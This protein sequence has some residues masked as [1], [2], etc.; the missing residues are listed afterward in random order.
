MNK[1]VI[2][3]IALFMAM[4]IG[5]EC[6]PVEALAVENQVNASTYTPTLDINEEETPIEVVGELEDQRS[7]YTKSFRLSDGTVSTVEYESDVHYKDENGEWQPIDNSL[8]FE[9]AQGNTGAEAE[10]ASLAAETAENTEDTVDTQVQSSEQEVTDSSANAENVEE[11]GDQSA[12]E[13]SKDNQNG[14][15]AAVQSQVE[16]LTEVIQEQGEVTAN[17][18]EDSIAVQSQSSDDV[19]ETDG[20]K[21][22][23]GKV[24]FKFAK[25]ANQKNLVR[26]NQGKYKLSI[27]LQKKNKNKAVEIE[28]MESVASEDNNTGDLAS[29]MVAEN[30]SS[31][32]IYKNIQDGIDLQYVTSGSNLKENIIVNQTKENYQFSFEI[33]AQNLAIKQE[34][35]TIVLYDS[36]TNQQV[37]EM[38]AMYME[39]SNGEQSDG[40]TYSLTQKNKKKYTLT[41]TADAAWINATERELPIIIDPS[42][43]TSNTG[44]GMEK[45]E[46]F[47]YYAAEGGSVYHNGYGFLGY[48]S[49]GD[50]L[51]RH[52]IQFK[53]LPS[54]PRGSVVAEAK[55]YYAQLGYSTTDKPWKKTQTWSNL[56]AISNTVS[57]YQYLSK[58][59]TGK[60][61]GW[62]ITELVKKRYKANDSNYSSLAL[63]NYDESTLNNKKCAKATIN[64][65]NTNG[66][67]KDGHPILQ[68]TYRDTRGIEDYYTNTS[69]SVGQAGTAYV[70]NYNN[71]LTLIKND[72]SNNG[73]VMDFVLS[74]VYNSTVSYANFTT[75]ANYDW[76]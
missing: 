70:G 22:E 23:A 33:K 46:I 64:Q 74:H 40:I 71:Q 3:R 37:Y 5:L 6:L 7:A 60:Y 66:K 51:Y 45:A 26:I 65:N 16:Q 18:D 54:L 50:H 19:E 10:A 28:N 76:Q 32:V 39:D 8:I 29:Q 63:V 75:D 14:D 61:V 42:L 36:S 1:A 49:S 48:D 2:Q 58:D 53:N 43:D 9:D 52:I 68:I 12:S 72:L 44:S 17:S 11:N 31:S 47:N 20:Y 73:S 35:N 56:P 21:T 30:I 13:V 55:I 41:I 24:N 57:D 69:Q 34:N 67:F 59:T 62:D 27:A 38:P 25:N 15:S 4:L